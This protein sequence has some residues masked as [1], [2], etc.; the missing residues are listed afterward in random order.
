[1]TSRPTT[2]YSLGSGTTRLLLGDTRKRLE[3]AKRLLGH[4]G[5]DPDETRTI[6]LLIDCALVALR[7]QT[8]HHAEAAE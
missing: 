7:E 8:N 2:L 6:T 1:M 3:E 4:A 5:A